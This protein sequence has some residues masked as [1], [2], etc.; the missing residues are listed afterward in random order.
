MKLKLYQVDAFTSE[1]FKGNPAAVVP[2]PEWLDD[3]TMQNI[4]L[5]NNLS[6]SAFFVKEGNHYHIRWFTPKVEVPLCGHATLAS[7]YVIFNHL[8]PDLN[9]IHFQ[10]KS[11]ELIV[12][13]ENDLITLNFPANKP[14]PAAPHPKILEAVT[15]RPKEILL[16]KSYLAIFEDENT[17]RNMKINVRALDNLNESGLIIS[18]KG[19]DVD[20]VSRF[21]LP[22]AGIDEDPVTGYAHTI[23]TPYWS[24]KL[25]KKNLHALQVSKRGGE[26]WLEDLGDRV[27]ISGKAKLYM[28]GEIYL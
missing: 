11:G 13:K 10:S 24:E 25:N 4:G 27:K 21:F 26:L 5:E 9:K 14:Q 17:V 3:E 6:E 7:S 2:L 28:I 23:L 22:T 20:F 8:K 12:T 16:N 18:A 15:T 1:L 19:N